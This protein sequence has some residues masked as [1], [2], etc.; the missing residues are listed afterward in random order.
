MYWHGDCFSASSMKAAISTLVPISEIYKNTK[1]ENMWSLF[2]ITRKLVREPS[3]EILNVKCLEYSSPSWTRSIL[4]NDQGQRQKY[5]STLI[6]FFV[7]DKWKDISGATERWKGQVENLKKYSSYQE[8]VGFDGEPI[9][10]AWTVFPG[11]SSTSL[12]QEIQK[13]LARKNIQPEESKDR[14]IFMSMSNCSRT[15]T[16]QQGMLKEEWPEATSKLGQ[17]QARRKLVQA[18]SS[19]RQERAYSHKEPFLRMRKS[20]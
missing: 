10:F 9:E 14:I 6:P 19:S 8:A 11:F 4:A 7:S 15:F 2:N 12:L 16:N 17:L 18:L 3:E 20:G 13:D 5:V 1:F